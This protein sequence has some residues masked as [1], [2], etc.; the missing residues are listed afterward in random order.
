MG[1]VS[2]SFRSMI[3]ML[4]LPALILTA[5][6]G[7]ASTQVVEGRATDEATGEPLG[8]VEI[9]LLTADEEVASTTVSDSSGVYELEIP[10]DGAYYVQADMLG[11]QPLRTPLLELTTSRSFTAAFELPADPIELEGLEVEVEAMERIERELAGFGVRLDDLGER[12]V[13]P[14]D[15]ARRRTAQDFGKVLQW[16]SIAGMEI[17]R[18]DELSPPRFRICVRLQIRGGCA[19]MVL[20]GA[21]ITHETAYDIPANALRAIVVLRP[22]ESTLLYGTD[23]G[24]GAVLLFTR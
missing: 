2:R 22:E 1:D 10:E 9:R 12:F 6:P 14:A 15:I 19:V 16:Q 3:L 7:R 8:L 5:A 24:S 17:V 23:G 13:S 18:E 20:N 4:W 11:Y 21:R